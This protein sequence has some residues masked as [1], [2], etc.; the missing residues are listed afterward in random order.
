VANLTALKTLDLSGC[1]RLGRFASLKPILPKLQNITLFG[2]QFDDLPPEVCGEHFAENVLHKIRAHYA[3]LDI[4]ERLDSELKVF[5]L[6]NGGVGK[7]QLCR[8]LS[9]LP[10]DPD[11]RSTHGIQLG[12]TTV[13]IEDLPQPNTVEP[14]G[15]WRSGYLPRFARALPSRAGHLSRLVDPGV[16]TGAN[17]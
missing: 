1:S 5:F 7:T 15:L 4:G 9:G 16:G 17:F 11:G 2:C 10:F 3:D 8:R 14:M 13:E 6:G 12:K